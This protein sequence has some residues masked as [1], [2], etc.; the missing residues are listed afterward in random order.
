MMN[1]PLD[2][3]S[4]HG[5]SSSPGDLA[6]LF[7]GLPTDLG[8]LCSVVQGLLLHIFWAEAYGV[9]LPPE[10][11]A[12]V[13]IRTVAKKLERL[14]ELDP[15]PLSQTRPPEQRLVGNCR[16]FSLLLTAILRHQGR[17]A[18]SRCGF[19]AYFIPD[20]YEDH[21]VAE[22]W[23]AAQGRWRL[24]D[25][26]LDELQREKLHISFDPLDVP[27]DQFIT[28]GGAW[29]MC[30]QGQADPDAFGIADMH[31]LWFVR[32]DFVRDVACLN[33]VELLPWDAW[34]LIDLRDEDLPPA[35][36]EQMDR[37]AELTAGDVP[38]FEPVCQ[39]YESD[40]GWKVPDTITSYTAQGPQRVKLY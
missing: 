15:R 10:R 13:Q 4:T 21:W 23:D 11:Q 28:G 8:E 18:R 25:A 36:L 40:P 33:E 19:G 32:G 16:D 39:L 20:H 24:V 22:V 31:G 5:W 14:Q 26:Q 35:A 2:F 3:F 12:E 29:Q 34:G 38:L 1:D 7:D 17:P 37:V 27:R 6:C 9:Q 30:R